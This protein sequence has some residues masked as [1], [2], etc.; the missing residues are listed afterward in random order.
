MPFS[1]RSYNTRRRFR[2]RSRPWSRL[3]RYNKIGSMSRFRASQNSTYKTF[4]F[5][6]SGT[7]RAN[8]SSG[9][10]SNRF[11]SLSLLN[12]D[13][14]IS[15]CYLYE[16]WRCIKII[17]TLYPTGNMGDGRVNRYHRGNIVS[18]ID[19]PPYDVVNPTSVQSLMNNSSTRMHYS[20][21]RIKRYIYRPKDIYNKWAL[22][23]RD[24][25]TQP[26]VPTPNVDDWGTR[27]CVFGEAFNAPT[28]QVPPVPVPVAIDNAYYYSSIKFLVQFKARTNE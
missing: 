17:L 3:T 4:W 11:N 27:I 24:N 23:T 14:F 25:S 12:I 19:P 5:S 21:S 20:N 2:R 1:R 7:V 8:V 26:P 16:Q 13:T 22:I 28:E 9:I 15:A 10:I 6:Q 18:Y